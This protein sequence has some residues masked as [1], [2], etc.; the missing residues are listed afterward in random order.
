MTS[1]L[2]SFERRILLALARASIRDRLVEP[3]ALDRALA[4]AE[5]TPALEAIR[6]AFVTL[7]ESM[8]DPEDGKRRLRGCIGTLEPQEPL[9]R[10]VI[11]YAAHS[12]F[13]DPRFSPVEARELPGLTL[14]VSALTSLRPIA[15][16]EEI[17]A[18]RDGVQLEKG[19]YRAVFLPQ[20]AT[21]QGWQTW[22][23]LEQL[24][25][26]AG[27]LQDGWMGATLWIFQADV[28]GE[29]EC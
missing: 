18:G 16:P 21:E 1:E 13:E 8:L 2:T 11:R 7:R 24:S 5:L 29:E 28:F 10:S 26:K 9:Y 6:G 4:S 22:Q 17:V 14:E 25:L 27:L 15:G 20:V 12:A 19:V 3:G 23:L